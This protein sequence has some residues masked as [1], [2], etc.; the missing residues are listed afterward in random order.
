MG[1]VP[2]LVAA[3]DQSLECIRWL[4]AS[5]ADVNVQDPQDANALHYL[6]MYGENPKSLDCTRLLLDGGVDKEV[7]RGRGTLQLHLLV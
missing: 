7:G 5:G 1:M 6:F 3:Y 4:L 2:L